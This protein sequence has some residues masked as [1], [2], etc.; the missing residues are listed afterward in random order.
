[1]SFTRRILPDPNFHKNHSGWYALPERENILSGRNMM[2]CQWRNGFAGLVF[3]LALTPTWSLADDDDEDIDQVLANLNA[4]LKRDPKN[5]EALTHRGTIW[6]K[7]G[8]I[9][10]ALQDF[11]AAIKLNPKG[12]NAYAMRGIVRQEQRQ[13]DKAL[14]DFNEAVRL[15]PK[16]AANYVLRGSVFSS[17]SDYD[18]AL[19]DFNAAIKIDPKNDEAFF[20]RAAVWLAKGELEKALKDGAEAARLDPESSSA[21]QLQAWIWA[22]APSAKLRDGKQALQAA[23]KACELS[24]NKD[25]AA[26]EALAAAH[27]EL[28]KFDEAVKWQ[29]KA[30]AIMTAEK[31]ED[32]PDAQA[33][34]KLYK[35][36]KP[37]R[38]DP[39]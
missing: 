20:G 29:T 22:T 18:K 33:R 17:R 23:T 36:R 37:F 11:D 15:D 10:K 32:L 26:L 12:A 6:H 14:A 31:D 5:A 28:A 16:D 13:L 1:V 3:V 24:E 39:K 9:D 34:L 19:A 38:E 2:L 21:W 27:A 30:I 4:A 25:A 8:E 35:S 7:K